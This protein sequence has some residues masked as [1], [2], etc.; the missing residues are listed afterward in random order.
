MRRRSL[1]LVAL[2]ALG[3]S[4]S[5]ARKME[6]PTPS[7]AT[8]CSAGDAC[9]ADGGCATVGPGCD[10]TAPCPNGSACGT[11]AVCHAAVAGCDEAHPCAAGY[12]CVG[13]T[14]ELDGPPCQLDQDCPFGLECAGTA[15][16]ETRNACPT[17]LE[18]GVTSFCGTDAWCH[19][20]PPPCSDDAAC[21]PGFF[22]GQNGDCVR[23]AAACGVDV[24]CPTP[25]ADPLLCATDNQ[26]CLLNDD[27]RVGQRCNVHGYCQKQPAL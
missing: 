4:C 25:C 20:V 11:D 10:A 24:P 13:R 18:C 15:C 14:C 19:A 3:A 12:R 8:G 21:P 26:T 23:G 17:G 16:V 1:F 27:C 22:C 9:T 2:A 7:C 5:S 6:P